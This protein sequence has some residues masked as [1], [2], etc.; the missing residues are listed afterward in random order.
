MSYFG[1]CYDKAITGDAFGLKE[2]KNGADAGNIEAMYLLSCIYG[3]PSSPFYD[4]KL[5]RFWEEQQLI[6]R[7]KSS[8][9]K[10]NETINKGQKGLCD[11]NYRPNRDFGTK[12]YRPNWQIVYS[13]GSD[14]ANENTTE[15]TER[16]EGKPSLGSFLFSDEGRVSQSDYI[17]F[18]CIWIFFWF[19]VS[20]AFYNAPAKSI[21][22]LGFLLFY[23]F[24][25]ISTKR[26]HD[27]GKWGMYLLIPFYF[28]Y[29]LCVSGD[30]YKNEYGHP[31]TNFF[32]L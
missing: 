17:V 32:D 25:Q 22:W 10:K 20:A 24:I 31:P 12:N 29:L 18:L 14:E 27:I 7:I 3:N 1:N 19:I 16:K 4:D 15:K 28:I 26:C 11:E 30:N 2:L 9:G 23:P 6:S 8:E 5:Y 13:V 21:S